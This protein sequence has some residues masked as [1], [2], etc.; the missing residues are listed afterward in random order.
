MRALLLAALLTAAALAPFVAA[1][2]DNCSTPA[3]ASVARPGKVATIPQ[4]NTWQQANPSSTCVPGNPL[5]ISTAPACPS[6]T[7]V[8]PGEWCGWTVPAGGSVTCSWTPALPG[9]VVDLYVGFDATGDGHLWDFVDPPGHR[10]YLPNTPMKAVNTVGA[11]ARWIAYP[12]SLLVNGSPL[13]A[14]TVTC[15]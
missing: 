3:L 12:V 10:G 13:D 9:T 5:Y 14:T 4:S 11:P 2:V 8:L 15:Y 7:A 1:G 6:T